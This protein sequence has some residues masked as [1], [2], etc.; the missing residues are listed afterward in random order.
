MGHKKE[1]IVS[2]VLHTKSFTKTE[3][4]AGAANNLPAGVRI[5]TSDTQEEYISQSGNTL[6]VLSGSSGSGGSFSK[7]QLATL[8][9]TYSDLTFDEVHTDGLPT[10]DIVLNNDNFRN[11]AGAQVAGKTFIFNY[12]GQPLVIKMQDGATVNTWSGGISE[13]GDLIN[14]INAPFTTA[15][16]LITIPHVKKALIIWDADGWVRATLM[17]VEVTQAELDAGLA[18][19]I[20]I[21][22]GAVTTANLADNAVTLAKMA[23]N[24]V[25]TAELIANA[26]TTAKILDANI[27]TAKIADSNVTTTKVADNAVNNTKVADMAANTV[28]VNAS[29]VTAD[30]QDVT[31]GTNTVLGRVAGNIVAGQVQTGQIADASVTYAKMQNGTATSVVGRSANT[32]GVSADIASSADGQFLSRHGGIV[33]FSSI[34]YDDLPVSIRDTIK[35]P[36]RVVSTAAININSDL[37]NGDILDGVTLVTGDRVLLVGQ[38][39]ASQNGP[40]IVT[41][42]GAAT[43]A[44]DFDATP[45]GEVAS[46]VII[47]VSEGTSNADSLW[48]LT[49]NGTITIGTTSLA[50][51]R[52]DKNALL[53]TGTFPSPVASAAV[54]GTST[55]A[56]RADHVHTI[57]TGVVATA[58]IVDD[59]VTYAKI[60][61]V[62]ATDKVLGRSTAGAGN[63]EEITM[64]AFARTLN[65]DIDAATA[66]TTL[67]AKAIIVAGTIDANNVALLDNTLYVGNDTASATNV[68]TADFAWSLEN[69]RAGAW[70]YQIFTALGAGAVYRRIVSGTFTTNVWTRIDGQDKLPLTIVSSS[71]DAD[72]LTTTGKYVAASGSGGLTNGPIGFTGASA[73]S[74]DVVNANSYILQWF[75]TDSGSSLHF[76]K[77]SN[78]GTWDT[79]WTQIAT[80]AG[81]SFTDTNFTIRDSSDLTRQA[82]FNVADSPTGTTTSYQLPSTAGTLAVRENIPAFTNMNAEQTTSFTANWGNH[83]TINAAAGSIVVTLQACSALNSNLMM[84]LQREDDS[85]NTVTVVAPTGQP[86]FQ[87]ISSTNTHSFTMTPGGTVSLRSLT[88][89]PVVT[90]RNGISTIS[91]LWLPITGNIPSIMGWWDARQGT[92]TTTDAALFGTW[93]DSSGAARNA[94]QVT[95]GNQPMYRSTGLNSLPA[96]EVVGTNTFM[97]AGTYT[98][99][100]ATVVALVLNPASFTVEGRLFGPSASAGN[101]SVRYGSTYV[102]WIHA[103][104]AHMGG[105]ASVPVANAIELW[106]AS[107]DDVATTNNALYYK[108]GGTVETQSYAGDVSAA[109]A[110]FRL[111]NEAAANAQTGLRF[112]GMVVTNAV[113][114][115][116]QRQQIEGALAW[117]H[118]VQATVL[119]A[120]HPYRNIAPMNILRN[121]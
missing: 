102:N 45:T 42:T 17:G 18:T 62:S 11:T 34:V 59:A 90:D 48:M 61:N 76:R 84:L 47:A 6:P 25:G 54:V 107:F 4:E 5:V 104:V 56:S 21:T 53:T 41:A 94:T 98:N 88:T 60:Q 83:Y 97:D 10:G 91:G 92:S 20:P 28:K 111:F 52:I 2:P 32:T 75:A 64:T 19:R 43:R 14:D 119:P 51:T 9:P 67:G 13:D 87:L 38:L 29:G 58:M 55:L 86:F 118:G 116:T 117:N 85:A 8:T 7:G 57:G 30:P 95:S 78:T 49:T 36:C 74:V 80:S 35:E 50:F 100:I 93:N 63:V 40:Y 82:Q 66:R 22:S 16:T 105:A 96:I 73:W 115:T 121:Y 81:A 69:F 79:S 24:S 46:G 39:V 114:T 12:T 89:L 113:L 15:K 44:T 120:G 103:G 106:S 31:I 1:I 70:R 77:R 37:N 26:V 110:T 3:V 101:L 27:T 112:G 65:D 71:T 99:D 109:S 68:P 33:G 23:D 72:T 108:N